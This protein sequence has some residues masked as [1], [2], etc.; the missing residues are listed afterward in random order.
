MVNRSENESLLRDVTL[1]IAG[2]KQ[3][4]NA[5]L[6]IQLCRVWLNDHKLG[7]VASIFSDFK[8]I[9][10]CKYCCCIESRLLLSD[11]QTRHQMYSRYFDQSRA[12]N[13]ES[14]SFGTLT[15]PFIQGTRETSSRITFSTVDNY[16]C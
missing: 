5:L 6:A 2:D 4:E 10:C 14:A 8:G 15:E 12:P 7:I 9:F 1:G 3:K 11:K 13:F 16:I